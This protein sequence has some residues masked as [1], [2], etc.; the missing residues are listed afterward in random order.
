MSK[1]VLRVGLLLLLPVSLLAQ[2]G[3]PTPKAEVFTG[4]SYERLEGQNLNGWNISIAGNANRNLGIVGDFAGHYNSEDTTLGTASTSSN[5]TLT[6]VLGGIRASEREMKWFTPSVSALFGFARVNAD[7]TTTQP[8]VPTITSSN[9]ETAFEMLVG[10]AL[11]INCTKMVAVR[12]FQVDYMV[13]RASGFK[14]EGVR[15]S[16]GLVFRLGQ[17]ND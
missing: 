10:A 11:D 12:A 16:G 9:D 14:H 13:L 3:V 5:L 8:N 15:V 6:S 2:K 7:L 1:A 4:Y 17:R